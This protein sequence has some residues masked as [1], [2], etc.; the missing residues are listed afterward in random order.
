M[1]V[2]GDAADDYYDE[3]CR[4]ED[5]ECEHED[6]EIDILTGRATCICGHSWMRSAA[7]LQADHERQGAYDKLC[8]EWDAE[9]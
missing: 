7:D 8:E 1:D 9:N 6:Y 3:E 4:L 2:M 5:L